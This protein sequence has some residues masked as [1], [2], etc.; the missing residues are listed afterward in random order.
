MDSSD[1]AHDIEEEVLEIISVIDAVTNSKFFVIGAI[2]RD[3]SMFHINGFD[4]SERVTNDID[5]AIC[6]KDWA[7][8]TE[9]KSILISKYGFIDEA[10]PVHPQ[11][12]ISHKGIEVDFL[13]F[14]LISTDN[15]IRWP[16]SDSVMSVAGFKDAFKS[17]FTIDYSSFAVNV[18]S[19][20][21][22]VAL[23]LISW[24]DRT[25][26][27]KDIKDIVYTIQKGPTA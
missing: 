25:T 9:V 19:V 20:E 11:R 18:V 13:P 1:L 6:V 3:I 27:Q 26:R 2:A 12:L 4:L 5:F 14:G 21:M 22:F 10:D 24:N 8:F 17:R 23:K 15:D 7:V 16:G